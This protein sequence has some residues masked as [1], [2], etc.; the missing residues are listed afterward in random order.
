MP[1]RSADRD[2]VAGLL[3]Q[4]RT[5]A[6]LDDVACHIARSPIHA[7]AAATYGVFTMY[8]HEPTTGHRP[9]NAESIT[10]RDGQLGET[11]VLVGG[12]A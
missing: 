6:R 5:T 1:P 2:A 11:L 12:Q 7:L 8:Q 4:Y 9:R 10:V 3:D